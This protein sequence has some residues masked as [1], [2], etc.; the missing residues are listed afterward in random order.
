MGNCRPFCVAGAH[1]QHEQ[2]E[3][4]ELKRQAEPGRVGPYGSANDTGFI[5]SARGSD[6]TVLRGGGRD[7][8]LCKRDYSC[9]RVENGLEGS[10]LEQ[11]PFRGLL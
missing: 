10:K 4:M 2:R 8:F 3:E 9:C 5:L 6:G 11:R 7:S 1:V